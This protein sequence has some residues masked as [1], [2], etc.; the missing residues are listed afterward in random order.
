MGLRDGGF[1]CLGL[2]R[3][4]YG[5]AGR[6]RAVIKSAFTD[7]GLLPFGP[8]GFRKTLGILANDYCKTPEQFRLQT[9]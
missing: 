5:N 6:I 2:S 3:E 7:A 4:S 8:H 9:H 1:A